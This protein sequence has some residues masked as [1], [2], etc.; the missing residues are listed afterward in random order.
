MKPLACIQV[1]LDG[2]NSTLDCYGYS[3][4][5]NEKDPAYEEGV[6]ILLNLLKEA[7]LPATFF[8]IGKDA[9][10]EPH[11]RILERLVADNHELANHT[12]NHPLDFAEL[13]M[14]QRIAEIEGCQEIIR[15][16]TGHPPS[17]FR[18]PG[19]AIS[20]D[21]LLTLKRMNYLYD[22]SV[23]P[24][25]HTSLIRLWQKCTSHAVDYRQKYGYWKNGFSPTHPYH[26]HPEKVWK[27][28]K[29]TLPEIPISVHPLFRLPFHG[30]YLMALSHFSTTLSWLFWLSGVCFYQ[31]F[32]NVYVFVIHPLELTPMEKDRRLESQVGYNLPIDRKLSFYRKLFQHLRRHFEVQS[33]CQL[34][35]TLTAAGLL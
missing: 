33:S 6:P 20:S 18:A 29:D 19:Y 5:D 4:A 10:K 35:K 31:S 23:F 1:D 14:P 7:G 32:R 8:L 15:Q 17:G 27:I 21:T 16:L 11:L 34:V 3:L 26:P 13:P 2:L 22:A 24:C 28:G 9:A 12:M 30:S 25:L